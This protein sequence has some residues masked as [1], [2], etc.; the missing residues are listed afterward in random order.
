MNLDTFFLVI[1]VLVM[2]RISASAYADVKNMT[3]DPSL[4]CALDKNI[5]IYVIHFIA[6]IMS[7][8]IILD[9][10]PKFVHFIGIRS[11]IVLERCL[12]NKLIDNNF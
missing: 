3:S 8:S 2:G 7:F 4:K 10:I 6:A 1:Y 12:T 11:C 5:S 9:A